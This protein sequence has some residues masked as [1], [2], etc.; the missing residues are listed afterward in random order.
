[1]QTHEKKLKNLNSSTTIE[2]SHTAANFVHK[3]QFTTPSPR[4]FSPQDFRGNHFGFQ[5]RYHKGSR[6]QSQYGGGR[7]YSSSSS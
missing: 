5:V 4:G 7:G 6:G 1:M 2:L 3:H